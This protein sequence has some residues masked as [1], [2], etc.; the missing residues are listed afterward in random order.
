MICR[1]APITSIL[2]IVLLISLIN[3]KT[4]A[5]KYW[6]Q[7]VDYQINVK[8]DD[9]KHELHGDIIITYHNNS[10]TA[11]S[12]IWMHLWPNAYKNDK[13]AFAI[14]Q[15]EN[16][17]R[18]FHY[19]DESKRGYIDSL[20][21][22]IKEQKVLV[23]ESQDFPDIAKLIL[24]Q[25]L[26][27][28]DSVII[29]TPFRVKLPN[30]FSRLG[31]V[32]TAYQITQ[33]Y[34]KP[35]VFDANGW[36]PIPYLDQGEFYSEYGNYDVKITLP[37]NYI[38]GAT[39]VLQNASELAFLDR[40]SDSTKKIK[41]YSEIDTFPA[42]STTLKT[43]HYVQNNIHDFAWFADK[44]FHVLS[45]EVELPKSKRKV[46]TYVMFTN[47]YAEY[48]KDASKYLN[49]AVYY[50]SLWVGDY[51]YNYCTAVDGALSAGAGM[52]YPMV[53]VIGESGDGKTL[54][55]VIAHEVGH[56]WFYGILGSNE[57]EYGWM[58]EGI[59]SFYE[60]RYMK[61]K[62]S[63]GFMINKKNQNGFTK[64]LGL[65]YFPFGYEQYL[66]Q[67]LTA[68]QGKAQAINT[69]AE[70]FTYLNYAA[71]MYTKTSLVLAYLEE[72]LGVEKFD[73]VMQTYYNEWKFKHPQP[74]DIQ[75]LFERETGEKLDWFFN[76]I[77]NS[78]KDI[79]FK[80]ENIKKV[81]NQLQVKVKNTSGIAGPVLI[82]SIDKKNKTLESYKTQAFY[83][84]TYVYFDSL[85]AKKI[86]VDPGYVI[87]EANRNNNTVRLRGPLKKIEPLRLQLLGGLNR[88]DRT[89][90][91]ISPAIG[92]NTSDGTLA[93]LALY[94]NF[95]PF[96]K[97]E[98]TLLPM[99]GFKSERMNGAAQV[100][101]RAYP[102]R[103]A[104]IETKFSL[105][106]FSD[107]NK[108]NELYGLEV[109]NRFFKTS[110]GTEVTLKPSSARSRISNKLSYR[111]V[112]TQESLNYNYRD[113]SI[114][115]DFS[116]ETPNFYHQFK[117]TRANNRA[118]N[119]NS[120]SVLYEYA[121]TYKQINNE[122]H[123]KLFAVFKQK[124]NFNNSKKA[125]Q[126]R[127]FAG[128]I[129]ANSS[130]TN[131]SNFF[132]L[133][134]NNDYTYDK[135]FFDRNNL[136]RNQMHELDGAFK[137]NTFMPTLRN[138]IGLNV[139]APFTTRFPIGVYADVAY[140]NEQQK[141]KGS[142]FDMGFGVYMPIIADVMEVYF[143]V[144]YE[145]RAYSTNSYKEVIRFMIDFQLLQPQNLKRSLQLF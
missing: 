29:S 93:G 72:Y 22:K 86:V 106:S 3:V 38:V 91:Y 73:S 10:N 97:L 52:E 141:I 47:K 95:F 70:E 128:T 17:S 90:L 42:S 114:G 27:P 144:Y 51:P 48:W 31:H 36:H 96:K 78:K 138:M 18:G 25:A 85:Q 137:A 68:S 75:A 5:Q 46:K 40:L 98:W 33:W 43:L 136:N 69:N 21:F 55:Q 45:S 41:T 11:L 16:L 57:R 105:Y 111:F 35:A 7:R 112:Y 59:N 65:H 134:G 88:P 74:A 89:N 6:Q 50:Y 12:E 58:D 54:D 132:S 62:Y 67:Q 4:Y 28:G 61:L 94:N 130:R 107:V 39:G 82:S 145:Q 26:A 117:Y 126:I 83:E 113:T 49:D 32:K 8:L 30:S 109:Y 20:D 64:F 139:K 44:R 84:S 133:S 71:I 76:D 124:I 108:K 129:F 102:E 79:D 121:N 103:V 66:T 1:K 56:N 125:I 60:N 2:A 99:Y 92:Y 63:D 115:I 123:H 100:V 143:P 9:Q 131:S 135:A 80:I 119:A 24:P 104:E 116:I 81:N 77:I 101:H 122:N 19:A 87:P 37:E 127:A 23:L 120:L 13:T 34:P 14:Q 15:L 118:I 142:T 53:T 110:L 140:S